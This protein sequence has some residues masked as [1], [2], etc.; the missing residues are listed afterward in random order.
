MTS[1][2]VPFDAGLQP[3]RTLLAWRRTALALGLGCAV[4][5]RLTI[6]GPWPAISSIG[7]VGIGFAAAVYVGATK[8]YRR[9]HAALHS[10][11]PH[12][13]AAL[14]LAGLASA[15][16]LIAVLGGVFVIGVAVTG[17]WR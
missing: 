9:V 14:P 17:G 3:E 8:R 4:A 10:G 13:G 15:A 1:I 6:T 2:E 7:I 16:L 11:T 5:V 12:G